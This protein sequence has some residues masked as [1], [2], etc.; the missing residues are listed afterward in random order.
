MGLII[1]FKLWEISQ[2]NTFKILR[3]DSKVLAIVLKKF[4]GC[5]VTVVISFAKF[6]KS[7]TTEKAEMVFVSFCGI[8][9]F[10]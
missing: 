2:F 3:I 8:L 1:F 7:K 9:I 4:F 6:S 5:L 10:F